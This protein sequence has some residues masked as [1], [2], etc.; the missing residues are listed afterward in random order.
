MNSTQ[1]VLSCMAGVI[2]LFALVVLWQDVSI[3]MGIVACLLCVS[4]FWLGW[5]SKPKV[6]ETKEIIK[7]IEIIKEMIIETPKNIVDV[8]PMNKVAEE[9]ISKANKPKRNRNKPVKV[10]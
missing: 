7:E 8:A 6:V 4:Q 10:G 2:A 3:A 9:N 5:F 1:K